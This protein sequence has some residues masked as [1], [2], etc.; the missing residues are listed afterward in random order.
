MRSL[1]A[2]VSVFLAA[3]ARFA[4]S[5]PPQLL[6]RASGL[7]AP[8]PLHHVVLFTLKDGGDEAAL[9]KDCEAVGALPGARG[10]SAGTRLDT[11]RAEAADDW[12]VAF[13]TAFADAAAYA[14]WREHPRHRDA[15]AKWV[16]KVASVAVHDWTD[17]TH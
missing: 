14:A 3:C 2:F 13:H 5:P 9:I 15:I 10:A 1:L 12:H 17:P 6:S 8:A 11:G 16:P 4:Y 7:E